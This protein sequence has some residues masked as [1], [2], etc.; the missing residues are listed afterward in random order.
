MKT[1]TLT[2]VALATAVSS[3]ALAQEQWHSGSARVIDGDTIAINGHTVRLKGIDAPELKQTC[4][5]T[6]AKKYDCGR[7]ARQTLIEL[8]N[9]YP[10][11]CEA[12]TKDK[13]GRW[14]GRCGT[15]KTA[16]LG[17]AMVRMG[18][19]LAFIKYEDTYVRLEQQAK[20][21]RAGLWSGTFDKP[22]DWRRD[23]PVK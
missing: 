3:F 1:L 19:A 12:A 23:H 6:E 17:A 16:D 4:S 13:Y 21:D 7:Y 8:I 2:A 15:S 20:A 18:W 9:G 11:A 5:L 10:V 22:W 14:L